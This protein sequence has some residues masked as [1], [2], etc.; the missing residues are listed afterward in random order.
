LLSRQHAISSN[1]SLD[2][3]IAACIIKAS[4]AFGTLSHRLWKVHDIRLETKI[5]VYRAV[6]L[7]SL[8]YCCESWCL[9]RRQLRKLEQFRGRCLRNIARIRW[10]DKA[11]NTDVLERCQSDSIEATLISSFVGS[12]NSQISLHDCQSVYPIASCQLVVAHTGSS[13]C[14]TRTRRNVISK[15]VTC[16]RTVSNH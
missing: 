16:Q 8:L 9:Y 4:T 14:V 3:E 11:P 5:A 10:Q 2:D 13:Y 12:G 7:S 6:V 15:R 1:S